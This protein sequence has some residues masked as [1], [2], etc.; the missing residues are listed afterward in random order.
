MNKNEKILVLGANGMVGSAIV[1]ALQ[2]AGYGNLL[3][4]S[5]QKLDLTR[6][7]ETLDYFNQ[8]RPTSVFLAAAKVGG[9]K[10]NNIY[11]A[12]FLLTN[13]QIQSH[14]FQAAF[15]SNVDKLLFLGSSCIYP[16]DYKQPLKEEYLLCAPLEPTNEPY[17]IA[18]IAG[19]KL[20]ENFKRQYNRNFIA[21]MPTNLYG[22][23]DNYDL[24][25]SHVIPGLIARLRQCIE[26]G[27]KTFKVWGSG[28]PRREFLYVDDLAQACL[29]LMEY[30]KELPYPFLNVGVGSDISIKEL[31]ELIAQKIGF[32]GNLVF[33]TSLPDGMMEKKL[34]IS[35]ITSL[36]WS[37]SV[38][39]EEGITKTIDFFC[40][41]H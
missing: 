4:P 7:Q 33:D 25:N 10:A 41:G 2:S 19:L 36:G 16:K 29:F 30:K 24:E 32:T 12:D 18:K 38:T 37:P 27:D 9:I 1:R 23:N 21:A 34:D 17:A 5:R 6:Q 31:A 3:T 8:H 40:N 39:L 28:R 22:Q 15:E 35:R 20:A 14:T 26:R 11:R 13:L